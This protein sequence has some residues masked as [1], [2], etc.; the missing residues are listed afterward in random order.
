MKTHVLAC[1][2]NKRLQRKCFCVN[3]AKFSRTANLQNTFGRSV[4]SPLPMLPFKRCMKISDIEVS[5]RNQNNYFYTCFK[6]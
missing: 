6:G 4:W 2:F 3:I 5:P 1:N